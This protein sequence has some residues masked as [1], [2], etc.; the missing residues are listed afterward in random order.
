M[1]K[2]V[3]KV[4]FFQFFRGYQIAAN[5]EGGSIEFTVP[6]DKELIIE[7][8]SGDGNIPAGQAIYVVFQLISPPPPDGGTGGTTGIYFVPAQRVGS[9]DSESDIFVFSE[10]MSVHADPGTRVFIVVQRLGITF[11]TNFNTTG[12]GNFT[13]TGQILDA[14]TSG[15]S[16]NL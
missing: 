4:A 6:A 10:S 15:I 3:Q 11:P 12:G 13:M 16:V 7:F 2:E 9:F 5:D 14:G 1:K 8:I